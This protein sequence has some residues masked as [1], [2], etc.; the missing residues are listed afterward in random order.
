M[1]KSLYIIGLVALGFVIFNNI[2]QTFQVVKSNNNLI[3]GLLTALISSLIYG[4]INIK[5]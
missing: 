1:K 4:I 3:L 2:V 5:N